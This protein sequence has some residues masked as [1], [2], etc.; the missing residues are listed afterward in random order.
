MNK[1]LPIFKMVIGDEPTDGVDFV[2]LVDEP[3]IQKTWQVFENKKELFKTDN[4]RQIIS[5]ALMVADL[6]IY[7]RDDVR[8]EYYVTFDKPTIEKIQQRFMRNGYMKNFNL[9]H[10]ADEKTKS[11][12]LFNSFII[13][14]KLGILTPQGYDELTDG[15]WFGS[16]K[17]EDK[18]FWDNYIKTGKFK[19]FSVEGYFDLIFQKDENEKDI[20]EKIK[21]ILNN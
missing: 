14:S 17:I 15:S 6:P 9:M 5:G 4:D 21:E 16:A 2:A 3:A 8:G 7:R 10:D 12:F 11:V 13:D 18:A 20:I 1:E 19:G